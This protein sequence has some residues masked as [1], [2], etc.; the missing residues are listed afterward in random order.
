MVNL[1]TIVCVLYRMSKNRKSMNNYESY[2][3]AKTVDRPISPPVFILCDTCHW[4]ATYFGKSRIPI[5]NKCPQCNN[6][7]GLSS[8]PIM[9]NESFTFGYD[10]KRGVELEFNRR[11]M[12]N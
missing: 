12:V 6:N 1:Y 5:D 7:N 9:A 11:S 4:C 10:D 2:S 8:L 3:I